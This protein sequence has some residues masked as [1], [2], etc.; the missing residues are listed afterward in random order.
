MA[1]RLY[2]STRGLYLEVM[3]ILQLLQIRQMGTP[4]LAALIGL[5]VT[6]YLLLDKRPTQTRVTCFL[7]GRCHDALNRLLRTMPFSTRCLMS[8][9]MALVKRL[10][11]A[12]YLILDDV[13]VEKAFAKR[14]KWAAWTY[15]FAQKRKVYGIHI[16]LLVWC[17]HDGQWRIPVAFRLL[18][19]KRVCSAAQYR[20]KLQL[21]EAMVLDVL[22]AQVPFDWV[23]FDT[24]YTAG[25][26]TKRLSAWRISWHGTLDPK[27]T[28]VWRGQRLAVR[29]LASRLR[30]KWRS[31]LSVRARA[32]TV[33][34]P[35]YGRLRLVVTRNRHGNYQYLVS[36]DPHCDLTTM[37]TRKRRRWSVETVFRDCK[38]SLALEACQAWVDP[39]FVRHV[40]LVLLTFVVLQRLRLSP[41]ESVGAVKQ[42]WQLA[43]LQNGQHPPPPLRACPAHL[44]ATA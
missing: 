30:L 41:S 24:H 25:W 6:G 18:R 2:G 13:V 42:R 5:A 16:V 40:A 29:T 12:G 1:S 11:R 27:T 35:T 38:Q 3:S 19:P 7:P 22:A 28:I 17:S 32:L 31:S 44:R 15:S 20:T 4:T 23:A 26:F 37:V 33:I 10:A 9:L 39:A 43:V 36:N 8:L 34:A 21:A 14:L